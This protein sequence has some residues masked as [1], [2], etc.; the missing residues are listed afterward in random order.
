MEMHRGAHIR[1]PATSRI[2][3]RA[4][5]A[6][7]LLLLPVLDVHAETT[8]APIAVDLDRDGGFD[9]D[10]SAM[11]GAW[12]LSHLVRHRSHARLRGR[13]DRRV[14]EREPSR[15]RRQGGGTRAA[16]RART[17]GDRGPSPRTRSGNPGV[18]S[19][20]R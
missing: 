20:R 14:A 7:L 15:P 19:A 8:L 10:I 1:P 13:T 9:A 2:A 11:Q 12:R 5:L 16:D 6:L 4:C 3:L 18:E 17:P